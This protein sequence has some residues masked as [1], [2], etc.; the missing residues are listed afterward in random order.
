MKLISRTIM[1]LCLIAYLLSL[2]GCVTQDLEIDFLQSE[3]IKLPEWVTELPREQ[4]YY[5]GIGQDFDIQTAKEKSIVSIGQTLSTRVSSV[6][7]EKVASSDHGSDLLVS[8]IS[9]QL[10]DVDVIGAKIYDQ[11]QDI[12]GYYWVLTRAPKDCILDAIEGVL[13]SYRLELKQ[14]SETILDMVDEI[15]FAPSVSLVVDIG[16]DYYPT[17]IIWNDQPRFI[18]PNIT[19]A[20][21]YEIRISQNIGFDDVE[22]Y[23]I[24]TNSLFFNEESDG[25]NVYWQ[26]RSIFG[27]EKGEW[28]EVFVYSTRRIVDIDIGRDLYFCIDNVGDVWVWGK[29]HEIVYSPILLTGISDVKSVSVGKYHALLQK[30]D[31]TLWTWGN[32]GQA[33]DAIDDISALN[34]F[35]QLGEEIDWIQ[36]SAGAHNSY[37][38][39]RNG[40]LYGWDGYN[41]EEQF[42]SGFRNS[43]YHESPMYISSGWKHVESRGYTLGV[44]LDG[45]RWGWGENEP[46]EHLFLENKETPLTIVQ[47]D[48][49]KNWSQLHLGGYFSVGQKL[50]G[51]YWSWGNNN[52]GQMGINSIS[53][54]MREPILIPMEIPWKMISPGGSNCLAIG[55]NGSLWGWGNTQGLGLGADPIYEIQSLDYGF[56]EEFVIP[57]PVQIGTEHDWQKVCAEE[58]SS[59][60]LKTDGTVWIWGDYLYEHHMEGTSA[61]PYYSPVK[62]SFPELNKAELK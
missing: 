28:S 40:D 51:T 61:P 43:H 53:G 46:F 38:I 20:D 56:G 32:T 14:E 21:Q 19:G 35:R 37:G 27:K 6:L 4:G 48:N 55:E 8:S 45:S 58:A 11:F 1:H 26:V 7:Q 2:F 62:I 41:K 18:W 39:S 54:I 47:I 59:M 49:N 25:A 60:A 9:E 52:F 17:G 44:K 57:Y 50:D 34:Q 15:S 10:S 31:G 5:F 36:F 3:I 42:D 33:T 30:E 29:L 12:N 16:N 23:L 13:L 22:P 24:S